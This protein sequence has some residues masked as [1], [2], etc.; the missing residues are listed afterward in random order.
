MDDFEL[1]LKLKTITMRKINKTGPGTARKSKSVIEP[2]PELPENLSQF[3]NR[4]RSRQIIWVSSRTGTGTGRNM[5]PLQ[6]WITQTVLEMGGDGSSPGLLA[7]VLNAD[8]S[9]KKS[10]NIIFANK[11]RWTDIEVRHVNSHT[12]RT[13]FFARGNQSADDLATAACRTSFTNY[14]NTQQIWSKININ[15]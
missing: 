4:T 2:E 9:I 12:G 13:N 10:I 3:W 11:N 1:T 14:T 7:G 6:E 8:T 15:P 5:D